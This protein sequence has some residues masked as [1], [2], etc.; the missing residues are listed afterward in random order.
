[1]ETAYPYTDVPAVTPT[2]TGLKGNAFGFDGGA[3]LSFNF[4][5]NFGVY[6]DARYISAKATYSPGGGVPDQAVTLGGFR[7]GGGL[8][9]SF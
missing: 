4:A 5:S 9:V 3:N 8:K 2:V 6:A 1:M 7:F